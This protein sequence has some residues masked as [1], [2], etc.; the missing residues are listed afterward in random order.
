MPCFATTITGLENY[1]AEEC[2]EMVGVEAEPDVGKIIFE[3]DV[4]QLIKLN[5]SSRMLHKIFIMLARTRVES[6]E[7]VYKA[8]SQ[9]DYTQFIE[10]NQTFAVRGERH[11]KDESFTSIDAAAT[12][13]RAIIN[14]FREKTGI[15]LRV[16]LDNP[17]VQFYCLIRGSELFLGLN[18]TGKSLHRRFYRVFH[19][20]AALQPT[21]AI[22]MMKVAGWRRTEFL[23][24]PMCGGGTI[25]IEAALLAINV[26]V[27]AKKL[28]ELALLKLSFIDIDRVHAIA[29]ELER[30][31]D[32]C[33]RPRIMGADASPKSIEGALLN[34]EKAGVSHLVEF[35][36]KDVFK[37]RDWLRDHPDHVMMN[38]PYGIRMG[39]SRIREFYEGV[40]A[41]LSKAAPKARLTAI[42][43]KPGIFSKALEKAGYT[44]L[45]KTPIV[46][47]KLNAVIISAER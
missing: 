29:E 23:L 42:V 16:N 9:I 14:S 1:A 27:G 46:Y 39:I 28:N 19:H 41:G 7:D 33:F 3:A 21:I 10:G 43:S 22:G 17:D 32:P 38:P 6:L 5:L 30:G 18:T 35:S 15:R 37:I 47:G 2:K 36:V 40:C 20:R 4:D 8:A 26:P 34:S 12:V 13:G 44:V 25:P 31:V 11:S 24:D 45:S